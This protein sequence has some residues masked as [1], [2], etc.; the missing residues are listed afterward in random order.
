M[1]RVMFVSRMW[2]WVCLKIALILCLSLNDVCEAGQA[3]PQTALVGT[4]YCDPCSYQDFSKSSHF[5]SDALVAVECSSGDEVE[6]GG[7]IPRFQQEV[8][9]DKK[10]EFRVELPLSI[11]ERVP[12]GCSVKSVRSSEPDCAMAI[13]TASSTIRLKVKAS[14]N[15]VFSAGSFAFKPLK[16][17]NHCHKK[18]RD[19]TSNDKLRAAT[20]LPSPA[21]LLIPSVTTGKQTTNFYD[22]PSDADADAFGIPF[23]ANPFQPPF[24]FQPPPDTMFTP[25]FQPPPASVFD[26]RPLQPPPDSVFNPLPFQPSPPSFIP[27]TSAPPPPPPS[28]TWFPAL[29]FPPLE[30][31]LGSTQSSPPPSV[32]PP[33]L[34][35]P[36]PPFP[37]QP[38]PGY[39]G[40]P[41]AISSAHRLLD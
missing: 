8:R 23:Q 39:P 31:Q 25:D 9:T 21:G 7:S 4:V 19:R 18:P 24:Q 37:F 13:P 10:G 20:P 17:P 28:P 2:S 26:P 40:T 1:Q 22:D 5:I 27:Q 29:T 12:E 15:R 34:L 32:P 3:Q 41:P 6:E 35:P 14:G 16:L 11:N 30:P 36:F 38:R 33:A